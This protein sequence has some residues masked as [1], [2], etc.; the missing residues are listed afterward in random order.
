MNLP[1]SGIKSVLLLRAKSG[2]PFD[3]TVSGVSMLPVLHENDTISICRKD[4]YEIGDILVFFYK[5]DE[6][7]V[8]RLLK[9]EGDRYFCKGDNAFRLEDITEEQ[10]LGAVL[11]ENDPHR[12]A[13]FIADSYKINRLFRKCGYDT[14]KVKQEPEYRLYRKKYLEVQ[15]KYI[16]NSA[17]EYLEIDDENLVV[18][19]NESGDSHYIDATGKVILEILES[20]VT[21]E[22]LIGQL[23]EIYSATAEEIT[24]DVRGFLGELIEKKVVVTL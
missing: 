24:E 4:R 22:E 9:I 8:H 7:L 11:L 16:R 14:E 5:Q 20:E 21:E 3:L 10:I 2:K 12:S 18:Y 13:E 15:M 1:V 19:D 23:C 6:L 17:M